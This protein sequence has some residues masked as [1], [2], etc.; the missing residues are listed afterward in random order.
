VD[1]ETINEFLTR[2]PFRP[3]RIKFTNQETVDIFS[4]ALVVVMKRE[5][6]I[7]DPS[8]DRFRIYWLMHVV[9]VESLQAA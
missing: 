4:P 8:R 2:Q 7:A 6:F 1:P 3:F 5:I 9:G